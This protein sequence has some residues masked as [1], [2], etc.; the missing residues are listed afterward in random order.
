MSLQY[1][2][3]CEIKHSMQRTDCHG[4]GFVPIFSDPHQQQQIVS[5][6]IHHSGV[7][8]DVIEQGLYIVA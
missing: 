2:Q 7:I 6:F 3:Y 1:A 4:L 5:D 8:K